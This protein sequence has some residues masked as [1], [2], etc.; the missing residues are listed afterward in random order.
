M[1]KYSWLSKH[2][3]SSCDVII[4]VAR[5]CHS[6]T[7]FD[8]NCSVSLSLKHFVVNFRR[9][10][11]VVYVSVQVHNNWRHWWV[12]YGGAPCP[13][14]LLRFL[15]HVCRGRKVMSA[16]AIHRQAFPA[17]AR[18]YHRYVYR[19]FDLQLTFTLPYGFVACVTATNDAQ[20]FQ[21]LD[22]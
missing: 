16:L 20:L 3:S 5:W 21:Y 1:Y 17:R 18:S 19:D 2:T 15:S 13:S 8:I 4:R 12:L 10:R 22:F 11:D 7:W 6:S 14:S 9:Q